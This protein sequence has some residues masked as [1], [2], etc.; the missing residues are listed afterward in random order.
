MTERLNAAFTR[1]AALPAEE[2]DRVAEWLLQEI[3]D[4]EL[5]D[6]QFAGSQDALAK[7]VAEAR[8]E[9]EVGA[10]TELD[11]DQL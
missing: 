11:P 10:T 4:E 8:R 6:R 9:H 2:Q 5:W 1:L 3:A 7:L